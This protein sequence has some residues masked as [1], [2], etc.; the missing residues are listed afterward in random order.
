MNRNPTGESKLMLLGWLKTFSGLTYLLI[1][2]GDVQKEID[3]QK[4]NLIK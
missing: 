4:I 1:Y 3:E 2:L